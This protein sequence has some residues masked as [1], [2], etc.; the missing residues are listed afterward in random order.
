MLNL[1]MIL[2]IL[3]ALLQVDAFACKC[4]QDAIEAMRA[5]PNQASLIFLGKTVENQTG[6]KM[7]VEK[8]W[9]VAKDEYLLDTQTS[10]RVFLETGKEFLVLSS[11]TEGLHSCS[12]L[13]VPKT[14]AG[15]LI[16]KINRSP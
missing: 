5:D 4:R 9:R 10:C 3:C 1:K 7:K 15:D 14:E 16:K 13:F 11:S 6:L 2:F 8:K 12:T